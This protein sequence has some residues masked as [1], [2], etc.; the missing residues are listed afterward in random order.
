MIEVIA[1]FVISIGALLVTI[2]SIIRSAWLAV[3]VP[4]L[5]A[6]GA[7]YGLFLLRRR[8]SRHASRAGKP[9][10]QSPRMAA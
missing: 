8:R 1:L 2:A 10:D 7:A 5:V 4:L 6:I 9:S 3:M